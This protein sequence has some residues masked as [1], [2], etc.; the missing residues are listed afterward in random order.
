MMAG[1]HITLE[2]PLPKSKAHLWSVGEPDIIDGSH[3]VRTAKI[4]RILFVEISERHIIQ[5]GQRIP[6]E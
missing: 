1:L 2:E 3:T 4:N 5:I 6:F